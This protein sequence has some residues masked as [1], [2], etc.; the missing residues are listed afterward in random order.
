MLYLVVAAAW[1]GVICLWCYPSVWMVSCF[2]LKSHSFIW[3]CWIGQLPTYLVSWDSRGAFCS[4]AAL[5]CWNLNFISVVV[6]FGT[7][8]STYWNIRCTRQHP[9]FTKL[10]A[11]EW[12]SLQAILHHVHTR[13]VTACQHILQWHFRTCTLIPD[14]C[15]FGNWSSDSYH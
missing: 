11:K 1:N 6:S 13:P 10:Q 14:K 2:V 4:T 5:L 9:D 3:H 12:H 8:N 15:S 7:L